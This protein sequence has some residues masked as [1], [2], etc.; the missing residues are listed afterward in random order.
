[1]FHEV[2]NFCVTF[3]SKKVI[4]WEKILLN[5]YFSLKSYLL[6]RLDNLST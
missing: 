3:H 1:M 5:H 4:M 2:F 6:E